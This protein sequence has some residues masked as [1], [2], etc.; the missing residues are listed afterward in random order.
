VESE[1]RRSRA[2]V[3]KQSPGAVAILQ[4]DEAELARLQQEFDVASAVT[5]HWDNVTSVIAGVL[6]LML[7]V[8]ALWLPR[9]VSRRRVLEAAD[10]RRE[11][12]R[13]QAPPSMPPVQDPGIGEAA[14]LHVQTRFTDW[15]DR[16]NLS[17]G[18]FVA[19]WA[20]IA[21]FAYYY[22]VLARYV[23]NSPTNWVHESM[24]LMFG[25]QYL[26]CGAYAYYEDQH[27]RVDVIYSRFSA[28]GKAL[29]DIVTFP[30][31]FV[32]VAVILWT[33]V[34]FALDAISLRELSFTEW[35]VQ[36]WLIKLAIPIGAA[37]LLLQ[38]FSKLIK[39]IIIASRKEA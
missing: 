21:V 1:V 25:M 15:I 10:P 29:A 6:G 18:E 38:G 19:Y 22:E 11:A 7:L 36:Y 28:R 16:I 8:D 34:R 13:P 26:L 20:V 17:V 2:E 35:A 14:S 27:V 3:Q 4:H 37:L 39:D 12:A 32:F 9:L 24:F 33:G 31:F 23:F 5:N 30:F